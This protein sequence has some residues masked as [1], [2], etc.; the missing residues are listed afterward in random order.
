MFINA[1]YIGVIFTVR[2]AK[3]QSKRVSERKKT[4]TAV[5]NARKEAKLKREL[6]KKE[7]KSIK[8]PKSYLITEKEKEHL[9]SIKEATEKRTQNQ[10]KSEIDEPEFL[11][12]LRDCIDAKKCDAFIEV[13]DYRDINSSRNRS[14]ENLITESGKHLFIF[15]NFIDNAFSIDLSK[16]NAENVSVLSDLSVL[17]SLSKI[18]IFGN[19][20]TGKFLLSKQIEAANPNTE[21]EFIRTPV[22][23]VGLSDFLRGHIDIKNIDS[24]IMLNKHW[25]FIN[26][27]E[28]KRYYMLGRFDACDSFIDLLAEK[29]SADSVVK[30]THREAADAFFSDI[31]SGKIRWICIDGVFHF[32]FG[33]Q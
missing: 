26:E 8:V 4:R 25:Q 27:E 17:S 2:M 9:R 15:V 22:N 1:V 29:L 7:R 19:P 28:I 32:Q 24:V 21:F 12:S 20:K 16:L 33:N 18:C 23:K 3:R 13:I 14:C 30:K 11:R 10:E 5:K 6:R 31:L